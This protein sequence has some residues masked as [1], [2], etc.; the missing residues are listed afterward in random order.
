M[1]ANV[2]LFFVFFYFGSLRQP[3]QL[4][5][6]SNKCGRF[7]LKLS[8]AGACDVHKQCFS[9]LKFL[10]SPSRQLLVSCFVTYLSVYFDVSCSTA[11]T[12]LLYLILKVSLGRLAP[13]HVRGGQTYDV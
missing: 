4:W 9:L 5:F 3:L 7:K 13:A 8:K 6:L 12:L 10:S 2:F 1:P 11:V